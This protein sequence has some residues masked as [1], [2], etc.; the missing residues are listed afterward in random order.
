MHKI[1][2][3]SAMIFLLAA[4]YH[5]GTTVDKKNV[6]ST[7]DAVTYNVSNQVTNV[8]SEAA[9]VSNAATLATKK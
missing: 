9:A 6:T 1:L 2:S 4:C 3:I 8:T 7:T 5:S